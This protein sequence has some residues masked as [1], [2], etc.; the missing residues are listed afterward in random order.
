MVT[1]VDKVENVH[2]IAGIDVSVNRFRREGTAAVV[3]I[4]YPGLE[5][6]EVKTVS[7]RVD[8]PYIPGL[9]SFR[10]CPLVLEACA[11][12][13]ITPDLF[14]VDGQGMAHPRRFGIASHLGLLLDAP[15]IGCAKSRLCGTHDEPHVP[16]GSQAAL[17]DNGE[18]LGSVLRTKNAVKPVFVS[19][20]YK[21]SLSEAVLWV[22]RCCRGFRLPEPT[23]LAHQAAGGHLVIKNKV[24]A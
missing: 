12:L 16:R 5:V 18:L 14:L 20:G 2:F 23:R 1:T 8:F 10:E 15:T 19:A 9:L 6:V 24:L 17:T 11:Q 3:V 13:T 4:D 7:G 21:I 22:L